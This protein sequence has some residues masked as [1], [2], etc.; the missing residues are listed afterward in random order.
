MTTGGAKELGKAITPRR[1]RSSRVARSVGDFPRLVGL[2]RQL[3]ATRRA[4]RPHLRVGTALSSTRKLP[5]RMPR[6]PPALTIMPNAC[7]KYVTGDA[8]GGEETAPSGH[9]TTPKNQTTPRCEPSMETGIVMTSTCESTP[10]I[11]VP[12]PTLPEA[13]P[14]APEIVP[15]P[16]PPAPAAAL[17][18]LAP[19]PTPVSGFC[20]LSTPGSDT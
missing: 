12:T 1:M 11:S 20:A 14:P 6:H 4:R 5:A 7:S 18:S 17:P 13:A 15:A 3:S 19:P 8:D 10:V 2:N 9:D 16:S